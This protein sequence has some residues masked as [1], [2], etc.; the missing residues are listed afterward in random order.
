MGN[1]CSGFS[2]EKEEKTHTVTLQAY[3]EIRII[4][5]TPSPGVITSSSHPEIEF[6]VARSAASSATAATRTIV[7]EEVYDAALFSKEDS[8]DSMT[9]IVTRHRRRRT[10]SEALE[11]ARR[12]EDENEDRR[13]RGR[14]RPPRGARRGAT[15][16]DDED[17]EDEAEMA[18]ALS[19]RLFSSMSTRA[20]KRELDGKELEET[21]SRRLRHRLETRDDVKMFS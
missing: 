19:K 13:T 8:R 5:P 1:V 18:T 10:E 16:E 6:F 3:N 4:P 11:D 17:V 20:K 7:Y 12:E 2:R 9:Q 21:A 14:G 15:G